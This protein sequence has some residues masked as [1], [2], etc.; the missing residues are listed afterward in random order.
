MIE[1]AGYASS[2]GTKALNVDREI[3]AYR[4]KKPRTRFS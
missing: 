1:V 3:A 2:T 4:R